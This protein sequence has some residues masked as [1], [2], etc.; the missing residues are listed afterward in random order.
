MRR[1]NI[2]VAE[3]LQELKEK[4]LPGV[5]TLEL[6]R[7]C[8]DKVKKY[9][10][11]AAFK[12]YRGYPFSICTSINEEV[13]HGLPST[14]VLKEGDI[15]SLDFGVICEGYYGDAAVTIPIGYVSSDAARL[16]NVTEKALD[17]AIKEAV[18]GKM[19]RDISSSIQRYAEDE[20]F[21]IVRDFV[22]HGIGKAL[23]EYPQVPNF[24]VPGMGV[25]LQ[26]GMVLAIEPML[27]E[28]GSMVKVLDDGWTAVTADGSLAAHFE[29]SVAITRNG[30]YILSKI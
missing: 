24:V 11:T 18:V 1:S 5:T 19:V 17:L 2:I 30:P 12:G 22:G 15:L 10:T 8:E 28:G 21:S 3:I 6:D 13:V 26:S 20:G 16:L 25:R 29:H 9:G 4:A 14:R 27:N 7:F 23:H